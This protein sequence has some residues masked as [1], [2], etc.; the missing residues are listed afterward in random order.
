[1]NSETLMQADPPPD[2]NKNKTQNLLIGESSKSPEKASKITNLQETE[3]EQKPK[4][5]PTSPVI[6]LEPINPS[7]FGSNQN[8]PFTEEKRNEQAKKQAEI[9]KAQIAAKNQDKGRKSKTP[10]RQGAVTRSQSRAATE[11]PKTGDKSARTSES[12]TDTDLEKLADTLSTKPAQRRNVSQTKSRAATGGSQ[13]KRKS[14]PRN[15]QNRERR[16]PKHKKVLELK[17]VL[18]KP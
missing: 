5:K 18:R 9:W 14:N 2:E 7:L 16:V 4:Q 15:P 13:A 3:G 10:E 11:S 1:M 8:A 17:P 6:I 12:R